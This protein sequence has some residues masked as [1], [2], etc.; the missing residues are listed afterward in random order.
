M[1]ALSACLLVPVLLGVIRQ[2]QREH[3][4]TAAAAVTVSSLL[5]LLVADTI[6]RRV[7]KQQAA[8]QVAC[9]TAA[10]LQQL[11]A[12]MRSRFPPRF[13]SSAFGECC[14][15]RLP[16]AYVCQAGFYRGI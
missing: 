9:V 15:Y 1:Q 4:P 7:Q 16:A 8:A 6:S 13:L 2:V 11:S 14:Y 12:G 10:T 3:G 5:L